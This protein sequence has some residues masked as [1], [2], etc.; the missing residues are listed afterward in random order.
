[1]TAR[2]RILEKL[3]AGGMGVVYK[4]EDTRLGRLVALKFLADE[5]TGHPQALSRFER[6]ARAAS[7]LNHANICTIHDIGEQDG[8]AFIVMEYLE[9]A[10][11]RDHIAAGRLDMR[12]ALA[13]AQEIAGALD[14]AHTAGII[15]RDIKPTN[16]FITSRGSA[17]ILDF[18]LA[19][20]AQPDASGEALTAPGVA[21]G[22]PAYMSPEQALGKV[23]DARSDI[24]SLGL[25]LKEMFP[26]PT[27]KLERII[28]KCLEK[29][30]E[31][32]Y[33]RCSGIRT[34]LERCGK[35]RP[36]KFLAPALAALLALSAVGYFR[37]HG[38]S[39]L[40]D[41]DT[42]VLAD[43]RN[44]TGDPVFDETLRQGLSVQL[45]Q[46]P[47]LSLISDQ[48]IRQTLSLMGQPP[49]ARLTPELGR[50]ICERTGSAAVLDGSIV[51]LGSQYVVGLR[52]Q[53][54]RTGDVLD[55]EQAQ[56]LRKED[57]LNAVSQ[58][59]SK[60]R[61]KAGESL[62]TVEQHATPLEEATTPSLEALKAYSLGQKMKYTS[63]A[64]AVPYFRRAI[65]IDPQFAAAYA[66]LGRTYNDSEQR[67]PAQEATTKGW[68]LRDRAS[69]RERFFI[70][71]SYQRLVLRNLEKARQTLEVWAQTYPRDG[72][73]HAFLGASTSRSLG[74]FEEAAEES[75][76]AT[77]LDPDASY[78][79][80]NLALDYLCLDRLPE[81]EMTLER[82]AA[83][84]QEIPETLAERYTI[85]VLKADQKEM[86]RL[87]ALAR[88]EYGATEWIQDWMSDMQASVLAYSG[89]LTAA[90]VKSRQAVEI[91]R[92]AGRLESA[93]Q[94]EVGVAVRE[95]LFGN[96][97]EARRSAAAALDLSD[98]QEA[99]YGAA[100]ALALAGDSARSQ[101][102]A[103]DLD[104]RSPEDTLVQ[105]SYLPVLRGMA[106][107]NRGEPSRAVELLQA[108]A[109]YELAYFDA[110][111]IGFNGS[112]YPIY[113][114][115]IAYLAAKQGSAAAVEFRKIL[116]H[117][118][119]V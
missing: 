108:A 50:E 71:F 15:H 48:R 36:W 40:T 104:K 53:N 78:P 66:W 103:D 69:D 4:A 45:E 26:A 101:K 110:N 119:I 90:R 38:K 62:A 28:S 51:A 46:S 11:L 67:G 111:S 116:D 96:M 79:Y 80:M 86:D 113:I 107:V 42:I 76:K 93:S 89:H 74:K 87:A 64:S 84:K 112:L 3:G 27:G 94:H 106:A 117:R 98:N 59:A 65:E 85:A 100:L 12:R 115:G 44:A 18:G 68:Q 2:Y 24:Y 63:A 21:M 47:F 109:P 56:A 70:T 61:T 1:M 7:A 35:P 37:L 83:R 16:I 73:A 88:S 95:A 49:D 91:A 13:L 43:F 99:Q 6:E 102:I 31:L 29:D 14:A 8:R 97:L 81:A 20:L 30:R 118:T 54:C 55:E 5:F 60:F 19:Q 58:V 75:R 39:R 114:R 22:T 105:L 57:I 82:A 72:N 32:R 52:A 23:L 33:Q 25:V 77:E 17:K 41:K 10:T 92:Q 9:G 34:D